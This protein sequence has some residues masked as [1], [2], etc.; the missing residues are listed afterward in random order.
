MLK[1][2]GETYGMSYCYPDRVTAPKNTVTYFNLDAG[3]T[4]LVWELLQKVRVRKL[5]LNKEK[6]RE[7][8]VDGVG[9]F[10]PQEQLNMS[11]GTANPQNDFVSPI[12]KQTNYYHN[13]KL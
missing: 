3:C 10:V 9:T 6:Q 8:R 7:R 2:A 11:A 4:H 1:Q 5:D 13:S 12:K